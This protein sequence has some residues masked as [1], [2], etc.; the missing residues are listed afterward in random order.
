MNVEGLLANCDLAIVTSPA[1][2]MRLTGLDQSDAIILVTKSECTYLTNPLY[3]VAVKGALPAEWTVRILSRREQ[4]A[5]LLSAIRSASKV[6]IEYGHMTVDLYR[7]L[8]GSLPIDR[9]VDLTPALSRMRLVKTGAEL[10]IIKQAEHIVDE[11]YSEILPL[12]VVGVTEREIATEI[13]VRM[14]AHGADG[15]AFD[16]IVAF[17]ERAAM[18]HAVPSD[19]RLKSGDCVLMD[20]GAKYRGYCSDFTR[21]VF[22]GEPTAA[23]R[24][25]YA[26]VLSAQR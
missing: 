24:E 17:G 23:F 12:L 21:T 5:F 20:F 8:F 10:A 16:T 2:L 15:T 6:G 18:P 22:L 7:A 26:L 1:A 13:M 3:E 4:S 25:A 11:V 19:R 14:Q 9:T